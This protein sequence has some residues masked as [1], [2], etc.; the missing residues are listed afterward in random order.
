MQSYPNRALNRGF[1]EQFQQNCGPLSARMAA[2]ALATFPGQIL[3]ELRQMLSM[4]FSQWEL[5][6]LNMNQGPALNLIFN[7]PVHHPPS[8]FLITF[9]ASIRNPGPAEPPPGAATFTYGW[10]NVNN[11]VVSFAPLARLQLHKSS[12]T[13]PTACAPQPVPHRPRLRRTQT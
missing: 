11:G 7:A 5:S 2:D 9:N 8:S 1:Y 6:Q 3:H 4:S 10:H 12:P 13:C